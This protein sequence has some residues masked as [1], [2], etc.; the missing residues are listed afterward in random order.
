MIWKLI[1]LVNQPSLHAPVMKCMDNLP[2]ETFIEAQERSTVQVK[3][4]PRRVQESCA[5]PEATDSP[6]MEQPLARTTRRKM[7]ARLPTTAP[8]AAAGHSVISQLHIQHGVELLKVDNEQIARKA[9]DQSPIEK[10][11]QDY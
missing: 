2:E 3:L 9:G 8:T 1:E 5:V 4:V 7:M 6:C 10:Q 11:R